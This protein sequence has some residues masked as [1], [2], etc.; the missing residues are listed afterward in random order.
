MRK[1]IVFLLAVALLASQTSHANA[2]GQWPSAPYAYP[3]SSWIGDWLWGTNGNHSGADLWGT[4]SGSGSQGPSVYAAYRGTISNLWWLCDLGGTYDTRNY[5][6]AGSPGVVRAT[7]Y[8]VTITND[9]GLVVH[10]WHMAD[11]GSFSSWVN[12]SLTVG[13][14]VPQGQWLGWQGNATGVAF[15]LLHLHVTVGYNPNAD[16]YQ[17]SFDPTPYIGPNLRWDSP[18]RNPRQ[19]FSYNGP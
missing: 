15:V 2:L 17:Y 11:Q 8:G 12:P 13:Q 6:C 19:F 5:N 1:A 9:D 3:T 14:W 4:E 18:L 7:K 16:L 10:N